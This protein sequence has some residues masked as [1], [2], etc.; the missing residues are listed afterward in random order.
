MKNLKKRFLRYVTKNRKTPAANREHVG[1]NMMILTIFIFLVFMINFI[2]IIGTDSKFGV[3]L[4]EK[5]KSVYQTTQKV[6]AKR[7]SIFDRVGEV[8][9]EDSTTYSI[10]AVIDKNYVSVNDEKLYIQSSQYDKVGDI[11][12]EYLDIDKDY[13]IEQLKRDASQVLFGPKGDNISYGV[14]T[15]ITKAMED[16]GIQGI[17]FTTSPGRMYPNGVFASQLIGYTTIKEDKNG[18]KTLTGSGGL[19]YALNDILSGTDGVVTY[20]KDKN[21]NTLLGT[22]TTVKK[23]LDGKDV[24]T[25][26]YAPLQTYLEAHMNVF[27]EKA[28]GVNASAT[29]V[30]AKTGEILATTQ[31]PTYD[32]DTKEGFGVEGFEWQNLLY[33]TSYEPG[34]TLK[35]MT[36]ASAIDNKTF[37][38]NATIDNSNGITVAD[39]TIQ[40]WD[41]NDGSSQG[42]VR[43][44]VQG[45]AHSSNVAMTQ[46]ELN[47]GHDTWLNYLEK[48]RF[49]LRTRFGM[50]YGNVQENPGKV[51]SD[52]VVT[53]AMSSFGQ[54]INV[55]QIQMLRAF[56]AISN[57]GVMLQP[58]FISQIYDPNT[59]SS[60]V[61]KTEV[62]GNPVS[63]EAASQTREYMVTV[64][65]DPIHGT[66][67][68]Q[69]YGPVI[70]V[71]NESVAVKSGTAQI[72]KENGAGY[73]DGELNNLFSVVA[74]VPSDDP[75]FIMY[76]T[77]QQPEHWSFLFW[78]DLVNPVLEEAMSMKPILMEPVVSVSNKKMVYK[79]PKVIGEDPGNISDELHRNLVSPIILGLGDK[80][81]KASVKKGTELKEN[82]QILLLTNSIDTLPDM[83][84]WTKKNVEQFAKWLDIEITFKG[85]EEGTVVKQSKDVGTSLK[86]LKKLTITLGD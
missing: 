55:S 86:K 38:P 71:G 42:T 8:I 52:N 26:L 48:F 72:A 69:E 61:G 83:Y 74:M 76:V 14:M 82:Q 36:V 20:Q 58:K 21:G 6:Q 57:D 79:L 22:A 56:T 60:R 67:Y 77:L 81:E 51:N 2:I 13:V 65:T 18:S 43:N 85:S 25:T 29:V 4:S 84:G 44:F 10:Y 3:D 70:Q 68:S 23:A 7:G 75:D 32:S 28:N 33:Q 53:T 59:D 27:Q 80:I 40:D 46:L 15:E 5:A 30:N 37:N 17:G 78:Q 19:E 73:L 62:V 11:L 31:R 24:Y 54:G 12:K 34:S 35:V 1:Q 47:M 49:G 66:L 63:A 9:A 41:I 16:A 45:F 50:G 39:T 64:G